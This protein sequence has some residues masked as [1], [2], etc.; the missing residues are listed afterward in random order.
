MRHLRIF[1]SNQVACCNIITKLKGVTGASGPT[2]AVN[3]KETPTIVNIFLDLSPKGTLHCRPAVQ[4]LEGMRSQ[5]RV[6]MGD[7][8]GPFMVTFGSG[9]CD[10]VFAVAAVGE[11]S[12]VLSIKKHTRELEGVQRQLYDALQLPA[13]SVIQVS[14]C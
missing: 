3:L 4:V 14:T 13:Q 9:N 1:L 11:S 5:Q 12:R 2:V 10:T 6:A 7:V 8:D